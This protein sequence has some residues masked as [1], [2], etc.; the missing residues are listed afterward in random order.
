MTVLTRALEMGLNG[1]CVATTFELELWPVLANPE[2]HADVEPRDDSVQAGVPTSLVGEAIPGP[3]VPERL[4][5]EKWLF[6]LAGYVIVAGVTDHTP[7][8]NDL[9]VAERLWDDMLHARSCVR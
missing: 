6:D 3:E 7:R 5:G 9:A 1:R 8:Q 2:V 4:V